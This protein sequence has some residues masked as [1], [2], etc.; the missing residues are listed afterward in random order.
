MAKQKP[1]PTLLKG[2]QEIANFFSQPVAVVQRWA[3]QSKMPVSRQGRN[4]VA[5]PEDL[6]HWLSAESGGEPVH[7]VTEATDLAG[8][9]RRALALVRQRHDGKASTQSKTKQSKHRS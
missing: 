9:L 6:N 1:E 8:D 3:K 5:N 4:V 7:V 2:W